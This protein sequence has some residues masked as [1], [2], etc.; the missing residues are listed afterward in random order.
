[1]QILTCT[2]SLLR[3][4]MI[5]IQDSICSIRGLMRLLKSDA[6]AI[7]QTFGNESCNF[8][9]MLFERH[10][11]SNLIRDRPTTCRYLRLRIIR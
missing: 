5:F 2:S 4:E 7:R 3:P 8:S 10:N 11:G 6:I 9:T 1:M